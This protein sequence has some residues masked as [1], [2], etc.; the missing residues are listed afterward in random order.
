MTEITAV[1]ETIE[2]MTVK[3][4]KIIDLPA[5]GYWEDLHG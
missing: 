1:I 5:I 2:T 3:Y 4:N